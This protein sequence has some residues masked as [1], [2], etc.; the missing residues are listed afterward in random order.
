MEY[1]KLDVDASQY[2]TVK[3]IRYIITN[4]LFKILFP[5]LCATFIWDVNVIVKC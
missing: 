2:G 5:T 1:Q 4:I 3:H